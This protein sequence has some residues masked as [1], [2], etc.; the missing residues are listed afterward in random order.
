MSDL[1]TE[2]K[3]MMDEF[4]EVEGDRCDILVTTDYNLET[5]RMQTLLPESTAPSR[6]PFM[7]F[8]GIPIHVYA[9]EQEATYIANKMASQGKKVLLLLGPEGQD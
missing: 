6:T 9:D 7:L 2:I 1:M 5:L 3:E 4:Q 8:H